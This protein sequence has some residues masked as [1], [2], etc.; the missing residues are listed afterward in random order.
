MIICLDGTVYNEKKKKEYKEE[1]IFGSKYL[2]NHNKNKVF[3]CDIFV[4]KAGNF[5]IIDFDVLINILGGDLDKV[6]EQ[7]KNNHENRKNV[8]NQ[9]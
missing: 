3:K 1:T 5:G 7:N 6:I 4:K 2:I 8:N 9:A